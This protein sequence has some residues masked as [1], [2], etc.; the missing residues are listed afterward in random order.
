MVSL[1]QNKKKLQFLYLVTLDVYTQDFL[2]QTNEKFEIHVNLQNIS[3][4]SNL[5][6]KP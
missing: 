6:L 2:F 4:A 5:S 3:D 1:K